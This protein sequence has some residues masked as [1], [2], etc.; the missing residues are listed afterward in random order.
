MRNE[1]NFPLEDKSGKGFQKLLLKRNTEAGATFCDIC[2]LVAKQQQGPDAL[3]KK[4]LEG[5]YFF[6]HD[7]HE[8]TT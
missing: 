6:Q 1:L 2:I 3:E 5:R 4:I 7:Q 8:A